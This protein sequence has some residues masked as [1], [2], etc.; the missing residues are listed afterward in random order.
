[1][2]YLNIPKKYKTDVMIPWPHY[3]ENQDLHLYMVHDQS[4]MIGEKI[5]LSY[6]EKIVIETIKC[7]TKQERIIID[8]QMDK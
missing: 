8:T 2:S 5:G 1:M 4:I 3:F 6:E 7:I